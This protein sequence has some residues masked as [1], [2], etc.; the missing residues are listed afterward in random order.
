MSSKDVRRDDDRIDD[1]H[2]DGVPDGAIEET[3]ED[4]SLD[5]RVVK[6]RLNGKPHVILS[7]DSDT[8][9]EYRN[10]T[11]KH[12]IMRDAKIEG[13]LTGLAEAE[14]YLVHR[15]VFLVGPKGERIPYTLEAVKAWDNRAVKTLYNKIREISDLEEKTDKIKN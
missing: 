5:Q 14:P 2:L 12:V 13:K 6:V 4:L 8:S 15:C 1:S 3:M 9:T 11:L 10:I 7:A